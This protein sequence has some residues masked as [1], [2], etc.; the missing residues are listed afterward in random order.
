MG[1][2]NPRFGKP[3]TML[4]KKMSLESKEKLRQNN[5]KNPRRYWLGKKRS[6]LDPNTM[7][8]LQK[9]RLNYFEKY[10]QENKKITKCEVCGKQFAFYPKHR[11]GRVCSLRCRGILGDRSVINRV[12][13]QKI[14]SQKECRWCHKKFKSVGYR[15]RRRLFCSNT[16]F[17]LWNRQY[18]INHPQEILYRAKNGFRS[19][20]KQYF[21]SSWEANIAR[22]FNFLG[23]NWI[24]EPERFPVFNEGIKKFYWPDFH[25]EGVGFFEIKGYEH[26]RGMNKIKLFR[27]QYPQH[28]LTVIGIKEYKKIEKEYAHLI[29]KWE[30]TPFNKKKIKIE[31]HPLGLIYNITQLKNH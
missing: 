21:R 3:G 30:F 10:A 11:S 7:A 12:Y 16:C 24:F 28:K 18:Q 22:Y 2:L 5:L 14:I 4:G 17:R 31:K 9:G 25:V 27:N 8:A 1:I 29:P 23:Y 13:P 19:D 6:L 15:D 20:I 26:E